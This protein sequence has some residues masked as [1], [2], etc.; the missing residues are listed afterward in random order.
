MTLSHVAVTTV[1]CVNCGA[2]SQ[3]GFDGGF[4]L[5]WFRWSPGSGLAVVVDD[6]S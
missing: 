2:M 6:F 5:P 1:R 4:A 3:T